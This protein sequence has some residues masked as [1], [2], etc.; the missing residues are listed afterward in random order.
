[1]RRHGMSASTWSETTR[2]NK[3]KPRLPAKPRKQDGTGSCRK[4]ENAGQSRSVTGS[5][6]RSHM[7]R[8]E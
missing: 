1:M 7:C 2:T 6:I 3:R 5:V 8:H 4:D